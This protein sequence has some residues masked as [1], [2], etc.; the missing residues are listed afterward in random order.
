[1]R[2]FRKVQF[3]VD[4]RAVGSIVSGVVEKTVVIE[5]GIKH[6]PDHC[7]TNRK[8]AP[9]FH[10]SSLVTLPPN[11]SLIGISAVYPCKKSS[12]IQQE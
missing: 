3:R 10:L 1:M 4:V 5:H 2:F 12:Y 11:C 9:G 8:F 7:R 6:L